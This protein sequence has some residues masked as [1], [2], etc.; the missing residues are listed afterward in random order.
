MLAR[1][2]VQRLIVRLRM[3]LV[4]DPQSILFQVKYTN[5]VTSNGSVTCPVAEPAASTAMYAF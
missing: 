5:R 1:V 2:R 4:T 3:E